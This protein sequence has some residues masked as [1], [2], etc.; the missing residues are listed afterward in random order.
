MKLQEKINVDLKE[1][2]K[3][4]NV[5]KRNLLRVVIGEINRIGKEVSDEAVIKI[6]R[7]MKENA[8]LYGT[9]NES[10]ILSEYLPVLLEKMQLETIINGFIIKNNYSSMKDMGMLMKELKTNYGAQI[11]GKLASGIIKNML[12]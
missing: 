6:I 5:E 8:N 1:S 2:M 10:V 9:S 12:S 4:K 11:D 7:K 3:N